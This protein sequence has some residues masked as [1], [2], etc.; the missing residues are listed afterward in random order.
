MIRALTEAAGRG[1]RVVI[2]L[3]GAIDNNIVRHASRSKLGE[4]LKAGIEIHEY[5]AALLHAK[6]MTIDAVWATVGST[7][8]DPRSFGLNEELNLVVYD[9]E[10]AER[11]DTIFAEDLTHSRKIDYE[12]WRS[13]GVVDRLLELFSLPARGQL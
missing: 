9:R 2:L 12:Q 11:L 3:P 7:N 10:V 6:T 5:K 1:V 8:L 4:L 13:R